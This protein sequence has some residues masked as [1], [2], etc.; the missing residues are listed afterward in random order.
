MQTPLLHR[1]AKWGMI[2]LIREG[3]QRGV[4]VN[5]MDE[6]GFTPLDYAL[7]SN[8]ADAIRLLMANGGKT[9]A[10]SSQLRSEEMNAM[11]HPAVLSNNTVN[12]SFFPLF[13][14]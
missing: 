11:T 14:L 1:A 4:D 9:T 5:M 10:N 7:K 8:H 3:L 12:E 13:A 6:F 2:R